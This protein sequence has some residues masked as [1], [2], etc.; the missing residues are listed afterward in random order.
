MNEVILALILLAITIVGTLIT[1]ILIPYVQTK[2]EGTK[3][4]NVLEQ[5]KIAIA[6]A[7]QLGITKQLTSGFEKYNYVAEYIRKILPDI[8]DD[9]I[10]LLIEG[11]GRSL[12]I[13]NDN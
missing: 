3:F 9:Q 6:A 7:E 1:K 8:T 5:V 13:F 10:E 11:T 4:N 12:G 2:I